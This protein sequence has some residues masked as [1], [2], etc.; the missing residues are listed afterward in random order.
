MAER[1]I[2]ALHNGSRAMSPTINPLQRFL[3]KL[4]ARSVLSEEE[5]QAI[6]HL[7]GHPAQVQANRDFVRL[8]DR[9][10]H[11][12]LVVEG[13]VGR[14][15]QGGEGN[16]QITAFHVPGDMP[17]L[18]SVVA[19]NVQ[20]A[21]QA[22]TVTTIVKVP[23]QAL[24]DVARRYPAVAEAFWRECAVDAAILAEWVFNVG[25]RDAHARAAHL[26]CEAA[27]RYHGTGTREQIIFGFPVT[28]MHLADMLA[29]TAVH[30]N[31]TLKQLREE[32]LADVHS[33]RVNIAD[34]DG[35][36]RAGD[37]DPAYLQIGER[38][39]PRCVS[40]AAA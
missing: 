1:L 7:P 38:A 27:C 33:K 11:A 26:L 3:D 4:T 2:V 36:V 35:L 37:F 22:L 28:Q 12:C 19:P 25:R 21:L 8:G 39:N 14:F 30:V 31:R 18:H 16:R 40:L 9:V 6:L 32:G 34:W 23:H 10:E 29:L 5:R 20:S 15:A 17:D 13:L 24:A